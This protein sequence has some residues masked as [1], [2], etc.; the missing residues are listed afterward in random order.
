MELDC[1]KPP[2]GGVRN[3]PKYETSPFLD[4]LAIKTR[5]R[6]VTVARGTTL[7]DMATGEIEGITEIAQV[8]EV[9]EGQFVKLFTKDLAIWFDFTKSGMRV[10]GALL[11]VVQ[12]TA[13]GRDLVYFDHASEGAKRFNLSRAVFYRGIDELL[14]KGFIARHRSAGW[15]FTNPALFFNGDRARFVKEYRKVNGNKRPESIT[16]SIKGDD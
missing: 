2:G 11:T 8:V 1:T 6:K 7:V 4:G 9:D 16:D 13:I 14:E 12:A 3:A 15:Y 10:F 5:G